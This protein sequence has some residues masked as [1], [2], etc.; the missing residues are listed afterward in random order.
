MIRWLSK[1]F[2]GLVVVGIVLLV[3]T[4]IWVYASTSDQVF[5]N[6]EE[7][8]YSPVGIVLGTSPK[9]VT[10]NPNPYFESRISAAVELYQKGKINHILVSG[11]NGGR[12]YNEPRNMKAALLDAGIQESHISIDNAG[13]RTLDSMVRCSRVFDQNQV[14][15]V[16]QSF[17]AHRALFI[18][19]YLDMNVHAFATEEVS[20]GTL[21]VI[22]REYFARSL[23]VWELY[24]SGKQPKYLGKKE[25]L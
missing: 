19:N 13:F 18:G 9:T 21:K 22:I 5:A 16:T 20:K 4:N 14:T 17:H 15:I 3:I 6:L 24:I 1:I 10:G 7:I 12:Y 23:A 8:P 2:L 11:D 25:T